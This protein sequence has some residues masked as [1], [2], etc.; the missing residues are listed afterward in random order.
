V[1][2]QT[3]NSQTVSDTLSA[4]YILLSV[5]ISRWGA[6]V[7]DKQI[8]RAAEADKNAQAGVLVVTKKL[9]KGADRDLVLL[10]R[11]LD[12][13]RAHLDAH[14]APWTHGTR[15]VSV[16][17]ALTLI[18]EID[19]LIASAQAALD[20]FL[21]TYDHARTVAAQA[22]GDAFNPEEYPTAQALRRRYA[23]AREVH[24]V[25]TSTNLASV[26]LPAHLIEQTTERMQRAL[27]AAQTEVITRAATYADRLATQMTKAAFGESCRL[28]QSLL[29]DGHAL[30]ATL[31]D[32]AVGDADLC[33]LADRIESNL[34]PQGTPVA[35]LRTLPGSAEKAMDISRLADDLK[36]RTQAAQEE[37]QHAQDP[38]PVPVQPVDADDSVEWF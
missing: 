5:S 27:Q 20:V 37:P 30:V 23:L 18:G 4:N 14:S 31:R 22:L 32:A 38:G 36:A 7:Q 8:A 25:P 12:Q 17:R 15:L 28:H 6:R 11:A 10:N 24:P 35:A 3:V 2:T 9:L 13:V 1:N 29:D 33:A 16:R 21:S 19:A 26:S 34:L